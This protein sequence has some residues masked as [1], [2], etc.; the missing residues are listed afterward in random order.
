MA[1]VEM[2]SI[3]ALVGGFAI[4]PNRMMKKKLG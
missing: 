4:P 3:P 1:E 2:C